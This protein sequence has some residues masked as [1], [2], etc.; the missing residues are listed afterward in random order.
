MLWTNYRRRS[1]RHERSLREIKDVNWKFAQRLFQCFAVA[2][3]PL[4]VD[5]LAEILAFGFNARP[6]PEIGA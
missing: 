6:I 2:S 3:R 1:M 5:E 4:G